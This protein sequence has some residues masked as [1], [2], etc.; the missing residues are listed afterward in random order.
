[1]VLVDTSVW[2]NDLRGD[3]SRQVRVLHELLAGEDIVGTAPIIVQEILQSA[4]SDE[5]FEK[6]RGFFTELWC[7]RVHDPLDTHVAAARLYQICR[8]TG[9]TPRSEE[10]TSELQSHHDLVCRLLLEKKKKK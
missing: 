2:V 6:W 3:G 5:R 1:M 8:R 7:Y 9:R 4:D 10:H